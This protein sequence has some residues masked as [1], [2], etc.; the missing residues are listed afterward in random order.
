[1]SVRSL[2]KEKATAGVLSARHRGYPIGYWLLA[3]REAAAPG[4]RPT[5]RRR[6]IWQLLGKKQYIPNGNE[7]DSP[8]V[9]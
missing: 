1:M 6:K 9:K 3:I 7:V 5:G 4:F 8:P 2:A